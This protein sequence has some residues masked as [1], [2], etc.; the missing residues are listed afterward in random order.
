MYTQ[1]S[2]SLQIQ[3]CALQV[4][5]VTIVEMTLQKNVQG[6][7]SA[8]TVIVMILKQNGLMGFVQKKCPVLLLHPQQLLYL[9]QPQV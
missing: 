9:P 1:F 7:R 6:N 2:I 8:A 3:M 4:V 5:H